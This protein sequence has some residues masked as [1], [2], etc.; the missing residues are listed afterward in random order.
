MYTLTCFFDGE[1]DL[2]VN[3]FDSKYLSNCDSGITISSS[4]TNVAD[5]VLSIGGVIT[6]RVTNTDG[7]PLAGIMVSVMYDN[8]AMFSM[9][10]EPASSISSVCSFVYNR[11]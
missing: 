11:C 1:Y 3:A 2:A 4:D 8:M 6:G 9:D 5:I 7:E 10:Y